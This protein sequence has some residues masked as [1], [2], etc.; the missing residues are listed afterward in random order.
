LRCSVETVDVC[1]AARRR[2]EQPL[3][4]GAKAASR[5]EALVELQ[6]EHGR[7]FAH[8]GESEAH[9]ARAMISVKGHAAIAHEGAPC[10]RRID[11]EPLE[12]RVTKPSARIVFDGGEQP[13]DQ[14]RRL[15]PVVERLAT[16]AGSETGMQRIAR[17]GE[18]LDVLAF[19]SAHATSRAAKDSGRRH[20]NEENALVARV[21]V[22]ESPVHRVFGR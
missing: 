8:A 7:S 13:L 15:V 18:E 12:V 10:G 1:G 21:V 9:A 4:G 22:D 6:I 5:F 3:E 11:A 20:A 19:R 16:A 2:A 17:G 14:R